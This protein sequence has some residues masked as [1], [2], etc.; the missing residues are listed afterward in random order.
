MLFI[1]YTIPAVEVQQTKKIECYDVDDNTREYM[2]IH[3][4]YA[5]TTYRNLYFFSTYSTTVADLYFVVIVRSVR[6]VK[7]NQFPHDSCQSVCLFH[8]MKA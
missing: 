1:E 4:I 7:D 8:A 3:Q 2:Y 5:K 6:S